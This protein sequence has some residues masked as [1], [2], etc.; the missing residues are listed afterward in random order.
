[1]NK[2]ILF[3]I[4]SICLLLVSL[5]GFAACDS[6]LNSSD[7]EGTNGGERYIITFRQDGEK[8]VR[9]VAEGGTLKYIPKPMPRPGYTVTWEEKDFTNITASFTVYAVETP[10]EYT[11]TYN[12]GVNKY[13]TLETYTAQVTYNE[14]FT[15]KTPSYS[16]SSEFYGWYLAGADGKATDEKAEDGKY[17]WA[18]DITLIAK[19]NEWS[20]V[21][22]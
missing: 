14:E 10:N 7:G 17:L 4:T 11:I 18:K 15:L 6:P 2:K 5:F 19:W 13:A 3:S 20:P 9:M 22:S 1:M 8:D 21:V 12:L 16:G